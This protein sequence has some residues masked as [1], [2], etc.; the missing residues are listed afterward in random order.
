MLLTEN[1]L[2]ILV[3]RILE[4]AE[5]EEV[6]GEPDQSSEDEVDSD[7]ELKDDTIEEFSAVGSGAGGSGAVR[8]YVGKLG[9][10]NTKD[11]KFI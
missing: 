2:R 11:S 4:G 9:N 3:R 6:L 7:D 1:E 10:K 8:G 5:D